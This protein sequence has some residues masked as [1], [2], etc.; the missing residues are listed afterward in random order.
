MKLNKKF[1]ASF[2]ALTM[3]VTPMA[4]FADADPVDSF[5]IEGSGTVTT[6]NTEIYNVIL[7]TSDSIA[8]NVDPYGLLTL[9]AGSTLEDVVSGAAGTVTSS[10][11]AVVNKSSVGIDVGIQ[12]YF[13]QASQTNVSN[14]AVKLGTLAEAKAGDAD[15]YLEVVNLSGASLSTVVTGDAADLETS[16]PDIVNN[17]DDAH[18]AEAIS[19]DALSITG[20]YVTVSTM[21]VTVT[22]S[23]AV[24]SSEAINFTLNDV[25]YAYQVAT[26][27]AGTFEATLSEDAVKYTPDNV[28]AFAITGYANPTSEVWSDVIDDSVN[29]LIGLSMKFTLTKH[30]DSVAKAVP[31]VDKTAIS[32]SSNVITL[33]GLPDGVTL[34]TVVATNSQGVNTTWVKGKQ[35]TVSGTGT[36]T[37]VTVG[38]TYIANN[39]PGKLTLTFSDDHTEVLDLTK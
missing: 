3:A 24:A 25:K 34:Q 39:A 32:A 5:T 27:A 23:A 18:T 2:T 15:L 14:A 35:Y 19:T 1:L 10:A 38:A 37:T 13:D 30:D 29:N 6:L 21:A 4:A 8:F 11:T 20:S 28:Y 22:N 36:S 9:E 33:T 17:S 12:V 31:Y 16:L 7:P 26:D